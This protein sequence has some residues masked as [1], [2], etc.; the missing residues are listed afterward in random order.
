MD[1]HKIYKPLKTSPN[2]MKKGREKDS[3]SRL[4]CDCCNNMMEKYLK[5]NTYTILKCNK[6]K[7][8]KLIFKHNSSSKEE[9]YKNVDLDLIAASMK[10][11]RHSQHIQII[12]EIKKIKKEGTWL[13][14]GCSF[15]WFLKKIKNAGFKAQ[16]I[17]PSKK[18]YLET[19]KIKDIKVYNDFFPSNKIKNKFDVI[20]LM[21]VFEHIED[22]TNFIQSVSNQLKDNGILIIK[23]PNSKAL[24][25]RYIKLIYIISFS[26][27]KEPFRRMWQVVFNTPHYY[28]YNKKNLSKL[29]QNNGLSLINYFEMGEFDSKRINERINFSEKGEKSNFLYIL[30]I[31]TI[32]F[33][34][35]L[36]KIG[37]SCVFILNKKIKK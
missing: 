14:I 2:L 22:P 8:E 21:D 30:T 18:V 32:I 33:I 3:N 9:I 23:V 5:D 37:D 16:G 26:K 35:K 17:E 13:D 4:I 1:K 7:L 34:S 19:K 25:Y 36:F 28:Y 29:L 31:K 11:I 27:L 12:K 20:S 15:G 10:H 6:C 24:L